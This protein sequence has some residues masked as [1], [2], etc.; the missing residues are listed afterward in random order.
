MSYPPYRI[1][2]FEFHYRGRVLI[3]PAPMPK[4]EPRPNPE[5]LTHQMVITV[6][7]VVTDKWEKPTAWLVAGFA[8][9]AALSVS[10]F[11][12]AVQL[13]SA[14]TVYAVLVLF[15]LAVLAHVGQRIVSTIVQATVAGQE[16]GKELGIERLN[17][18][19]LL[20]FM[21]GLVAAYP[22]PANL[23]L[24]KMFVKLLA[25]G[26]AHLNKLVMRVAMTAGGLAFMQVLLGLIA[27][28]WV[29]FALHL[30][31]VEASS[32]VPVP[33]VNQVGTK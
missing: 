23:L 30:P 7:G 5:V 1:N 13:T 19:E 4:S 20:L 32:E 12:K 33:A 16:A 8:A 15:F 28:A 6:A 14:R 22:W 10:N 24:R 2:R 3:F 21:G 25:K 11:D 31:A 18:D 17:H 26:P 27:I 9:V 29:G